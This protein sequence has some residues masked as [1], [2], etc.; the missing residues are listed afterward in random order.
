MVKG[1]SIKFKS[2]AETIPRFLQVIKFDQVIKG[3]PSIVLKPSLKHST[4]KNTPASFVEEVLKFCLAHKD[5]DA[6]VLIAEGSD[7]EDTM[8][9]YEAAGY[10]QLAEK[11]NIS[12]IDLNTVELEEVHDSDFIK[13][14]HIVYPKLLLDSFIVSLPHLAP[15]EETEMQ[16]S[17]STMLGA[18]PASHYKGFFSTKKNKMRSVPIKYAIH[19]I[20]RCKTPDVAIIDA[21]DYGVLLAGKPLELDKQAAKILGKDW[22]AIQHLRLIDESFT[23]SA[24]VEAQRAAA[25]AA[26]QATLQQPTT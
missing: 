2:Y 16:G 5:A 24:L 1:V 8:D 14:E 12:L 17:L 4:A 26:K 20:V 10:K 9:V 7:G 15:D 13:F 11:Y 25:K 18:F 19:D 23:Q 3:K 6:K 22:K 21:S